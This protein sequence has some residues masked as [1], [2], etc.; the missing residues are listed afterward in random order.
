MRMKREY[1]FHALA[2]SHGFSTRDMEKACRIS[3]LL[4]DI[5]AVKFLSE[6]L[7]LY[8]GTALTFIHSEEIMRLSIDLDLNYRHKD[9]VDWGQVRKEI[10]T[11]LKDLLY[12]QGY[13][14]ADIAINASYPLTRFTVKYLDANNSG[15]NFKIEIGYMRRT[16]ILKTDAKA[17][18]RHIGTQETF[19]T[20]TPQKEELF[21]NKWCAMLYRKTARDVFDIYRI[22]NMKFNAITFRKCAIID[23]LTRTKPKL[24]EINPETINRIPLDS[25]LRNLLQT[26]NLQKLNFTKITQKATKF[27][28][29]QL[30][31]LTN[32]EK[33][34][35]DQF[36]DKRIFRPELINHKGI[37]HKK[38]SEYPAVLWTLEKL[39]KRKPPEIRS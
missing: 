11:R 39:R 24:Y 33:N 18:F 3:D 27:T 4:E 17:D 15:D 19:K 23:S 10:D 9:N 7:S 38:T 34:M 29:T 2:L 14:K 31:K 20:T 25:S 12:R 30:K 13:S 5:S 21:A 35:I 8:G 16:P 1:D 37:F 32:S 26:E 22:V 6:R 36:W 28:N